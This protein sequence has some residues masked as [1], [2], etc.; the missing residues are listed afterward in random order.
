MNI[1]MILIVAWSFCVTTTDHIQ[2]ATN[3]AGYAIN[4]ESILQDNDVTIIVPEENIYTFI[5]QNSDPQL[6][7]HHRFRDKELPT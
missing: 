1:V 6:K 5:P 2:A 4:S 7:N 3:T